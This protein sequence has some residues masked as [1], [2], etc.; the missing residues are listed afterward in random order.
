MAFRN[1]SLSDEE[2]FELMDEAA[3][4]AQVDLFPLF[5]SLSDEEANG[6]KKIVQ[7]YVNHYQRAGFVRLGR[8]I[9]DLPDRMQ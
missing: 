3:D 8:I 6:I 9:R 5:D 4:R 1:S 2:I 7:W